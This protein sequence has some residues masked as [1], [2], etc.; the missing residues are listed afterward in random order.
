MALLNDPD[1]LSQGT[2]N[3]V[4]DLRFGVQT[5]ASGAT[6]SIDSVGANLPTLVDNDYFEIRGAIDTN[7]NGLYR[8]ADATPATT[9]IDCIKITGAN[10]SNSATDNTGASLLGDTTVAKNIFFD[11][12][13]KGIYL[14]EQNGLS[15]DGVEMN[16]IYSFA[17]EE[18]KDDNFLRQFPFPFFAVDLDAGKYQVGT[19]GAN[20]NGWIFAADNTV[21]GT[22]RTRKLIRSGGWSHVSSAGITTQIFSSII[23]LGDFE[24][25]TTDLAYYKFGTDYTVDDNVDFDFA[26]PVNEAILAYDEIGNPT[27]FTY[28]DGAG[29]NDS[30]TRASGS[31]IDDGFKVG[32]KIVTRASTT[33]ANNGSYVILSVAALTIEVATGS[34]TT[35]EADPLAQVAVDN[36]DAFELKLRV[37]DGDPFGKTFS[38]SNLAAAGV[39]KLNNF[40]FR[41]PL[42][43]QTDLNISVTDVGIDA[44]SDGTADVSPYS[45]MSITYGSSTTSRSGLVGGSFDFAITID[46]NGGTA[47]QVYEFVQWSLRSTGGNGTGDVDADAD[48]AIGRSVGDLLAFEGD[49]L[50]SG[51]QLSENPSSTTAGLLR[52]VYITNIAAADQNNLRMV[53]DSGTRR[54]FPETISVTLDFNTALID[55]TLAEYVLFFD[56]TIRNA[57]DAT[58]VITAGTGPVGTFV[59]TAQFPATLD[60]G[61][62]SY[63]RV[64]GLTGADAAMNGIYQ[65]TALTSTSLWSVARY[66]GA[67]IVTTSGAAASIDEHPIDSPDAIIVQDDTPVNVEGTASADFNF[68]FDFDANV[69][70]G[71]TVSTDTFVVARAIGLSGAQY[72]QSTVQTIQSGTPLTIVLTASGELNYVNA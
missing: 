50:V 72:V 66:D 39:T 54:Q 20:P 14:V 70:G 41:F 67:T 56:R 65:V 61:V 55:D 26:G 71:R 17:K 69:Q 15:A 27:T 18:W 40:I 21:D 30:V 25:P 8:V 1:Q 57:V 59:S 31:F 52:G 44:N 62:N 58:F 4:A 51:G 23:T 19:D 32:G 3:A 28:V 63:V 12:A 35:A 7:N 45:G 34:F 37:R 47:L 13:A 16:S 48:V 43:N 49:I 6:I 36:R 11:T 68:A 64:S 5:T 2:V 9:A 24:A 60:G 22:I 46:A 10:P 53:D 42:A 29:G 38:S 33:T